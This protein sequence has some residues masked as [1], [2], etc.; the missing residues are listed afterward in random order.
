VP[1]PPQHFTFGAAEFRSVVAHDGEGTISTA[2]VIA[3]GAGGGAEWIDLVVVPPGSTIGVH[4]HGADE[5]TYVVVDGAGTM[6][7]DGATLAVGPGDVV[8]NRAGGT[9]GLANTGDGPMRLVVV[10]VRLRVG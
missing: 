8:V 10:D 3:D 4:T 6:T 1:E 5:E 7:V 2:R 9:H